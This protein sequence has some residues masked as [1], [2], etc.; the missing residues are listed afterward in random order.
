MQNTN[1]IK[2]SVHF[3]Q[4]CF[5]QSLSQGAAAAA[6]GQYCPVLSQAAFCCPCLL[7]IVLLCTFDMQHTVWV[8]SMLKFSSVLWYPQNPSNVANTP[9]WSLS[10]ISHVPLPS[11]HDAGWLLHAFKQARC[12]LEPNA[13][14]RKHLSPVLISRAINVIQSTLT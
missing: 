3:F 10:G 12:R 6:H 4:A 2:A 8:Y 7:L 11:S 1:S 9:K 5:S 14:P 13:Y